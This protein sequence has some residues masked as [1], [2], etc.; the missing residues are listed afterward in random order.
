MTRPEKNHSAQ[1]EAF[2]LLL[3]RHS[4]ELK[5]IRLAVIGSTRNEE[6]EGRVT[7]LQAAIEKAGLKV[8]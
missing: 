2:K 4:G 6:D 1:I 7:L 8:W 3:D 5:D